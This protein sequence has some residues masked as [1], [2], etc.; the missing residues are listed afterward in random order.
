MV[1]EI[2]PLSEVLYEVLIRAYAAAGYRVAAIQTYRVYESALK[3]N[4]DIQPTRRLT[5]L[6]ADV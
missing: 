4:L 6:M 3:K 5:Q 1:T 2:E